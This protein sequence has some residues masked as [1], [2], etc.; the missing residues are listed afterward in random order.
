[1]AKGSYL[2]S[3]SASQVLALNAPSRTC[4]CLANLTPASF[5]SC[6]RCCDVALCREVLGPLCV[7]MAHSWVP[8]SASPC[9]EGHLLAQGLA[10]SAGAVPGGCGVPQFG[11]AQKGRPSVGAPCGTGGGLP[12]SHMQFTFSLCPVLLPS[13]L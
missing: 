7:L 8:L 2:P 13:F 1:M 5:G 6:R 12:C 3:S 10:S 11:T 4:S 9:A